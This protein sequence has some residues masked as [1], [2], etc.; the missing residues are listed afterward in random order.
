MANQT[1]ALDGS[2]KATITARLKTDAL[3]I[4]RLT[5]VPTTGALSV[6]TTTA[7]A[8]S[9]AAWAATDA[10]GRTSWFAVS[11]NDE[12]VLVALQCDSTGALL[13]KYV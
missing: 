2:S 5:A 9:P 4:T 8:V 7:G 10:N 11:E 1:A 6:T 13:V 3:T 12:T